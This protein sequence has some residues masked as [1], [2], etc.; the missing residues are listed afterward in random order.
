MQRGVC[1][2]DACAWDMFVDTPLNVSGIP[3][4]VS[5]PDSVPICVGGQGDAPQTLRT[6]RKL[7]PLNS[8][9]PDSGLCKDEYII[10]VPKLW[11]NPPLGGRSFSYGEMM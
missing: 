8:R 5:G 7:L 3:Y 2:K 1:V 9:V 10:P 11:F 4:M 6:E